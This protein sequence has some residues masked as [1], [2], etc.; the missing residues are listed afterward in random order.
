MKVQSN[1]YNAKKTWYKGILYDSKA[2]ALHAHT[3]DI[4]M[5]AAKKSERIVKIERQKIYDLPGGIRY[6]AD[7]RATYADGHQEIHE[8]KG[9][10]TKEW[11]MKLKLF[12]VEYPNQILKV[13]KYLNG[14][15][16]IKEI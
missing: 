1:K 2:E 12:K 13:I 9:F 14:R 16:I 4:L 10:E 15:K 3:L 7:F 5:L 11:R 6:R 8:V